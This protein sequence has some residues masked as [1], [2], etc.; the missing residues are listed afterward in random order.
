MANL[1]TEAGAHLEF[2]KYGKRASITGAWW[3]RQR[4]VRGE[5]REIM[6]KGIF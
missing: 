5:A 4:T 2:S 6:G 1:K 3:V